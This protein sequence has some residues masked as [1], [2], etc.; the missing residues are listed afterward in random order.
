M[1]DDVDNAKS[2]ATSG[3]LPDYP[4]EDFYAHAAQLWLEKA[5]S[6]LAGMSLLAVAQGHK[7]VAAASIIDMDLA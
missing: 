6:Q 2:T 4:G 1:G 5:Q 7:P 3:S